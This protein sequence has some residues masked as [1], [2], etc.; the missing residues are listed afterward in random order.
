MSTKRLTNN[1]Q[2]RRDDQKKQTRDHP[3]H[4]AQ[5]GLVVVRHQTF[6]EIESDTGHRFTCHLK[7]S[8]NDVVVGDFVYFD[9]KQNQEYGFILSREER[10][11]E[12]CRPDPLQ[13]LKPVAANV[14]LILVV[15]APEPT[16]SENLIDRYLIAASAAQI[17]VTLVLNKIDLLRSH[18]KALSLH[19]SYNSIGYST[20]RSGPGHAGLR[21]L[22]YLIDK[23]TVV[24]VG[25]SGVGKSTLVNRLTRTTNLRVGSLSTGNP[26]GRHTTTSSELLK[27]R[28]GAHVID[29]PGV[30]DF[31]LFHLTREEIERGFVEFRDVL[32][33]CK[34][35]NCHHDT[36][37]GCALRALAKRNPS[38]RARLENLLSI[39]RSEISKTPKGV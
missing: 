24:F 20:I 21:D 33:H 29:S 11:S 32:G 4:S 38:V 31:G 27:S 35:R 18:P 30:R 25:Q 26:K 22:E 10:K 6:A 28:T 23:K 7:R 3:P 2:G 14:D 9:T 5:R 19:E 17:D 16:P 36:E 8:M 37:Q 13:R 34:F 39:L 15:I 12:L 1:Q